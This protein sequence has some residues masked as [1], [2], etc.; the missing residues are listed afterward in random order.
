MTDR[1]EPERFVYSGDN[2]VLTCV[3]DWDLASGRWI[4][5]ADDDVTTDTASGETKHEAVL[6]LF[7]SWCVPGWVDEQGE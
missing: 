3:V 5:R 1:S 2:T 4:A 7:R 6:N